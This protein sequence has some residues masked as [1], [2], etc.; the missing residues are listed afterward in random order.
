MYRTHNEIFSLGSYAL[1]KYLTSLLILWC[2]HFYCLANVEDE[3]LGF[4]EKDKY[5]LLT[6]KLFDENLADSIRPYVIGIHDGSLNMITEGVTNLPLNLNISTSALFLPTSGLD[7]QTVNENT[8]KLIDTNQNLVISAHVNSTGGGDAITLVPLNLLSPNTTYKFEISEGVKDLDGQAMLPFSLTFTTG[9]NTGIN[10]SNLDGVNFLKQ[11]LSNTNG[12]KYTSLAIGPDGKLYGLTI[13]GYIRRFGIN[14]DGSL[15]APENLTSLRNHRRAPQVTTDN[16][17]AIGLVFDPAATANNLIAWVSYCGKYDFET[18]PDWDGNIARLSGSNLASVEDIVINLPRSNRTHLTNSLVF[19]SDGAL[20]FNQGSNTATGAADG[21][22]GNRPEQLLSGAVLRLDLANWSGAFPIDVKTADGGTYNPYNANVPLTLYATGVRNAYD[23]VWHSNNQLYIPTN[24]SAAGG[25]T[26]TSDPNHTSYIA[27]HPNAPAYV[28][29]IIPRVA[30]VNP[31][32]RDWLYR[33]EAGGYYGHPNPL[34]AEYVLNRGDEDVLNV[35]YDNIQPQANFRPASFDFGT[36]KSPNGAIEYKSDAFAGRLKGKLLVVRYSQKDDIIVLEPGGINQ[37]IINSTDGY[38]LGL[39][40]LS[41]PLDLV[42]N[43]NNGDLY[44]SEYGSDRITLFRTNYTPKYAQLEA[45]PSLLRDFV[46]INAQKTYDITVRNTGTDTLSIQKIKINTTNTNDFR[47][48]NREDTLS[49]LKLQPGEAYALRLVFNPKSSGLKLAQV[50]LTFTQNN[51]IVNKQVEFSGASN[52]TTEPSLQRILD[53]YNLGVKVGDNA[54]E[55]PII[56]SS[57]FNSP[58]LGDEITAQLFQKADTGKISIEPLALFRAG[59]SNPIVR[60]GWYSP[61][62]PN[63]LNQTTIFNN[64]ANNSATLNLNLANT[65]LSFDPN[66]QLF[67]LYTNWTLFSSRNLFSQDHLNTFSQAIPHH[68][69]VYP[70]IDSQKNII[71]NWYIVAVEETISGFEYNDLVFVIKNVKPIRGTNEAPEITILPKGA[72][73]TPNVY[74]N[75]VSLT[76]TAKVLNE[77]GI[78]N[79]RYTLNGIDTLNYVEPILIKQAGEYSLRAFAQDSLGLA[80]QSVFNFR[81]ERDTIMTKT[82]DFENLT[83]FPDT[84]ISFPSNNLL[85]FIKNAEESDSA[86]YWHKTN[87]LRIFNRGTD[88]LTISNLIISNNTRFVINKINQQNYQAGLLPIKLFS[89]DFVDL[90]VEFIESSGAKGVRSETLRVV[91]DAHNGTNMV[92]SLNGSF[93]TDLTHVGELTPQHVITTM[94]FSTSIGNKNYPLSTYPLPSEVDSGVHAD[95]ILSSHFVQADLNKPLGAMILATLKPNESIETKFIDNANN[96]LG[97]FVFTS[98]NLW[99]K[100]IFP[101]NPSQSQIAGKTG[102]IGNTPFR[103]SV[104]GITTAGSGSINPS[105]GLPQILGIRVYKAKDVQGNIIPFAYIVLPDDI[106][107]PSCCDWNDNML[108]VTN[109]RPIAVPSVLPIP[110]QTLATGNVANF[111]INS[112]F[113]KGYPGNQLSFDASLANNVP[114]PNWLSLNKQ[115]GLFS[116]NVP[117]DASGDLVIFVKA[118]DLNG[119]VVEQSFTVQIQSSAPPKNVLYEAENIYAVVNEVGTNSISVSSASAL[120]GGRTVRLVDNGD[121]IRLNFSIPVSGSYQLK[122][123]VRS[124]S[125]SNPI[126]FWNNSYQFSLNN[127]PITLVGNSATLSNLVAIFGGSH[128][129]T[130]ESS[131]IHLAMGSHFLNVSCTSNWAAVDFLEVVR[132]GDTDTTPPTPPV[133]ALVS[134]THNTISLSWSGANDNLAVTNYDIYNGNVLVQSTTN[135]SLIINSLIPN[136]LYVFKVIAKDAAGNSSPASNELSVITDSAPLVTTRIEA[137]TNFIK[138]IDVDGDVTANNGGNASAFSNNNAVRLPDIGDKIRINFNVPAS[139]QYIIQARVRSGSASNSTIYWPNSYIFELNNSVITLLGDNSTIS[140]SSTAFGG[141]FYG[142][143]RS[144][145]INLLAGSCSLDIQAVLRG[146][147]VVDYME[148][149]PSIADVSP[150]TAPTLSLGSKTHNSVSLTW[151]G[152]TDNVAVTSYQ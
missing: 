60:L 143:M 1:F 45:N 142:I 86:P 104:N 123:R 39:S 14:A 89:G 49:V 20:Y 147:G 40:G 119:L 15:T 44:V 139:G 84:N 76:L 88:T 34:R 63:Q 93:Q 114:L 69:R 41:D 127:S 10:S 94:G 46:S 90:E 8:V 98:N 7:N 80:S 51:V 96:T 100:S 50:V 79:F 36:N 110:I 37:D 26:P 99:R 92:I 64:I 134:K 55:S 91:S 83:K 113:N 141:S 66:A 58:I 116:G 57:L 131:P 103:V 115:S 144:S 146:W 2:T 9:N 71:P 56:H 77:S 4:L 18:G 124:G 136:T 120:S 151:A 107:K 68:Y 138:L 6:S 137:E 53:V 67:G 118:T 65:N 62:T 42:E 102:Q 106:N 112:F 16:K 145:P 117:I 3:K 122:V 12:Y 31:S 132:L 108:Y 149:V 109:I 126:S 38:L 13:D 128:F 23:L 25:N 47:L 152:A 21:A 81:I 130:M 61:L 87:Y 70:Y 48:V 129:G 95:L 97:G 85:A 5:L 75:F 74:K 29:P 82:I 22:W 78:K 148:I 19:G 30:S 27:P 111:S 105:T 72:T 135:N 33:I 59:S 32:Q 140:A 52:N 35:E 121:R 11:N 73:A 54:L 17:I 101:K 125:S 43:P 24:G 133:L 28:G 150:P